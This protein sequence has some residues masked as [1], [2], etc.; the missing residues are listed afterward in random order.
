[1]RKYSQRSLTLPRRQPWWFC[2]TGS[3]MN[4]KRKLMELSRSEVDTTG[5]TIQYITIK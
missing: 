2:V 4:E 5:N 1:M 3:E